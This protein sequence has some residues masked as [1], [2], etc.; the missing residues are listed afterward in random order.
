MIT[1]VVV[2]FIAAVAGCADAGMEDS[3]KAVGVTAAGFSLIGWVFVLAAYCLWTTF[4]YVSNIQS[5]TGGIYMPVWYDYSSNLVTAIPA[6]SVWLGPGWAT[7]LTSSILVFIANLIHCASVAGF[8]GSE[9]E[10]E[11]GPAKSY[12][13][14]PPADL[15]PDQS[16]VPAAVVPS[17]YG[18]NVA[19]V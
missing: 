6:T 11:Q 9:D 13:N 3:H 14:A 19:K 10:M 18:T 17:P 4:P 15:V 5:S 7:A 12:N 1:S 2:V 16:P 8:D